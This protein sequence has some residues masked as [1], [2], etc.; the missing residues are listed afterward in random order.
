VGCLLLAVGLVLLPLGGIGIALGGAAIIGASMSIGGVL[1][2]GGG[3]Y[4]MALALG[5]GQHIVRQYN[6]ML[7]LAITEASLWSIKKSKNIQE[8]KLLPGT[9]TEL[10]SLLQEEGRHSQTRNLLFLTVFFFFPSR[11][12]ELLQL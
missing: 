10:E 3:G 5:K 1:G 9:T 11:D 12:N 4:I 2:V 8:P 7:Q 6:D